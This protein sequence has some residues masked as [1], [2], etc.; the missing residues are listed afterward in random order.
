MASTSAHPEAHFTPEPA[1][2]ALITGGTS[3]LGA[4]FAQQLAA[5][6]HGL[7]LVA[8]DRRRLADVAAGLRARYAVPVETLAAD[9]LAPEGVAEVAG[10]LGDTA[11]PVNMLV[12]NAGHGLAGNFADNGLQEE[13]DLL[14]IHA[15]VPLALAHAALQAMAQTGGGRIVNVASVAAFTPNGTYS[16]AKALLV[17]FSR[18]A[19]VFYRDRQISVTALCPGLVHSEFHDRMGL[20]KRSIPSWMWLTAD[21]VV[22]EGLTDANA[23]KPV[24]IPSARYKAMALVARLAPDTVVERLVRRSR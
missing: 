5:R 19:N 24:S 18:W 15:E 11:N 3:G 23:G 21:H 4:E 22:R 8:R 12:N 10:R 13:L 7:V 1:Y 20:D 16:A 6:G 9:L 2:T 17:N 14:R